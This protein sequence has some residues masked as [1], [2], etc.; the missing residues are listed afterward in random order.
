MF[1]KSSEV[2]RV[3]LKGF[4]RFWC[5]KNFDVKDSE[6]SKMQRILK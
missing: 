2:K 4:K 5:L 6:V 3:S 1:K